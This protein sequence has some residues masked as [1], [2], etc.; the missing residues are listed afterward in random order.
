MRKGVAFSRPGHPAVQ[1]RAPVEWVRRQAHPMFFRLTAVFSIALALAGCQPYSRSVT[2]FSST[3]KK[4]LYDFRSEKVAAILPAPATAHK[5]LSAAFPSYASELRDC[6][7]GQTLAAILGAAEGSFTAA[8]VKQ[9]AYLVDAGECGTTPR[10]ATRRMLVFGGEK[11]AANVEAPIGSAILG[12][13]D[14][15]G[16]RKHEVLL[17]DGGA[18]SGEIIKVARLVEFDKDKLATV[19]DFGRIYDNACAAPGEARSIRASLVYY[20]P[21]PPG[22][23]PRFTVELYRAPCPAKGQKPEWQRVSGK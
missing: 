21:P 10:A 9:T 1:Q 18:G 13:Y 5:L 11:L 7:P 4:T 8:G 6:K 19:E 23:K 3:D 12:V 22:Q 17:E 14:L 15:D 20:L 2:G 16:D